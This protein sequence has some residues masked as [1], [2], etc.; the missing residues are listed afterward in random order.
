MKKIL[1][2]LLALMLTVCCAVTAFAAYD[3]NTAKGSV[4]RIVTLYHFI[5]ERTPD[6]LKDKQWVGLGS[7]FAIG[8]PGEKIRY[9]ATAAH[10]IN[11]YIDSGNVATDTEPLPIGENGEDIYL[12][13]HVD[14]IHVLVSDAS[15]YILAN[16]EKVSPQADV[17]VLK[18]VNDELPRQAAVL[19]DRKDF[20]IGETL[21]SMGFP[22]AAEANVAVDVQDQLLATTN[23][24]TTNAGAFS[25]WRGNAETKRGDQISTNADMSPGI[26]GGPLVDKDGYVVGVCVA[27]SL[28]TDNSNYAV[29][30][31]ELLTVISGIS[32]CNVQTGPIKEGLNTT[33]I[34]IIAAG[35]VLA[36]VLVALI[37]A[38]GN[39]K[40]NKRTLVLTTGSLAGKSVE[41]K[42]GVPV[43][44]G[45]DPKRCQIVY[46]KDTAGVS[47]VHCTITFNGNEVSV[48]DNGSSYGTFIGGNKVE[49]GKPVVMHRG[50]EITF[51][52]G[53]NSAELH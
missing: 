19:W 36:A 6:A 29:A 9:I 16:V 24:V 40:K 47:S 18:L 42:K 43:V 8:I 31:D 53:K 35:V 23:D 13:V 34:I 28:G 15:N 51:G 22:S 21:H 45:R 7:G 5:D 37:I 26:S 17:A 46:P 27:H 50:Q 41:L 49:P 20:E 52:S 1:A 10:V 3:L 14:E 38:N 2:F 44:I 30:A 12:S 4:V 25:A 11:R 33:T 48:A 32:Q 39:S